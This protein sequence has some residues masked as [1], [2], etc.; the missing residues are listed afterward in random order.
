MADYD[1]DGAQALCLHHFYR[2]MAGLGEI[3]EPSGPAPRCVKDLIEE[4]LFDRY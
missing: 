1:I 2:V 4:R 3:A